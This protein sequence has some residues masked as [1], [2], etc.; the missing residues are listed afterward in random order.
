MG[1]R[2]PTPARGG[3]YRVLAD[4]VTPPTDADAKPTTPAHQRATR[5]VALLPGRFED[6]IQC[7]LLEL[8]IGEGQSRYE[9]LSYTWGDPSDKVSVLVND[10]PFPVTKNLETVLRHLRL[11]V[12]NRL[13]EGGGVLAGPGPSHAA[14]LVEARLGGPGVCRG[15]TSRVY[16]WIHAAAQ[17]GLR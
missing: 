6:P 9:A 16:L 17:R 8:T 2:R 10:R 13:R 4:R 15:P 7:Q 14:S 3:L 5:F 1:G 12:G 11:E